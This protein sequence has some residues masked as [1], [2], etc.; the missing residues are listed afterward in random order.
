MVYAYTSCCN[1]PQ[2]KTAAKR[3]RIGRRTDGQVVDRIIGVKFSGLD[4]VHREAHTV[5]GELLRASG[6]TRS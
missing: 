2:D 3:V 5:N 6:Q 1:E 4:I